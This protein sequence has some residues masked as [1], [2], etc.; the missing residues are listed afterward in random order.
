MMI[1]LWVRRAGL[2][3]VLY[4][5][6]V[7]MLEGILGFLLNR[8]AGG[9]GD[10]L[11]LK[12]VGTLISNPVSRLLPQVGSPVVGAGWLVAVSLAYLVIFIAVSVVHVRRQD[13]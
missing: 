6:Y 3:I 4:L 13:L 2:A 7:I 5:L 8:I 10:F 12:A 11:P 9:L 1:A